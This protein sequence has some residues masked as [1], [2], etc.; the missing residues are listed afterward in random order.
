[1]MF[2]LFYVTGFALLEVTFV[3]VALL[4][5][6]GLKRLIGSATLY[7][8]LG[9]MLVF[10]HF[11]GAAG[12]RLV[13][14]PLGMDLGIATSIMLIPFL[15]IL[16][17]IY[18]VDGTLAAQRL[19]IGAFGAYGIFAY[20]CWV[21][22]IQCDWNGFA[23]SQ[24]ILVDT[25]SRIL[26]GANKHMAAGLVSLAIDLFLIPVLFQRIKNYGCHITVSAVGAL[27][28]TQLLDSLIFTGVFYWG[29]PRYFSLLKTEYI[30]R[31]LLTLWVGGLTA[32][33]LHRVDKEIPGDSRSALDMVFAFFGNYGKT[34]LLE[35]NLYESEQ[36]YRTIVQNASDM[37]LVTD[38]SGI[39]VDANKAVLELFDVKTISDLIGS[40]LNELIVAKAP[41]DLLSAREEHS[42]LHV[43]LPT[44]NLELEFAASHVSVD[45]T[46]AIVLIGRDVTARERLA[47]ERELL[48]NE[49]AHRQRLEAIGRLAGGIA[50]DFNNHI[51]AIHGHLD[52]IYMSGEP[53][54]KTMRHLDKIDKIAQQAG[55]LTGQLLGYAR[56]GKRQV[57]ELELR[58][59]VESARALFIPDSRSGIKFSMEFQHETILLDGDKTQLQQ[60]ILNLMINASDA[61]ENLPENNRIMTIRAGVTDWIPVVPL[62]P[63]DMKESVDQYCG[64]RVEDSGSG[65]DEKIVEQIFEP[66]FTTKP[67]GKGTGMGLSMSYG[68]ALEHNGWIQYERGRGGG[69][70][71]TILLP[72][73]GIRPPNLPDHN[74]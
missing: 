36:R 62:P 5:L 68:V 64:I 22:R 30:P 72:M 13:L 39:I 28:L 6:H 3:F 44:R 60:A 48:R 52:L 74:A 25:F 43:S 31:V 54:E 8:T 45:G 42:V 70:A 58:P 7:M 40:P 32:V 2:E 55:K 57:E 46:P 65:V 34:K 11:I 19:I 10:T 53:G 56:K 21:T 12:L 17:I 9:V 1:M 51:H 59:L 24:G 4:I 27:I 35:Q 61:M 29:E 63:G 69:A 23:V 50:H 67:T 66:F 14:E 73:T 47:E 38:S 18:V 71:F 37:I 15:A 16:L 49:N 41:E 20:L 26:D 33:Y